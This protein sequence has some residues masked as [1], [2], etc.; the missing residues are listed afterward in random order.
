[1][2]KTYLS[3]FT[4]V[5]P[6]I[7]KFFQTI[8][9]VASEAPSSSPSVSVFSHFCG[10]AEKDELCRSQTAAVPVS[11]G[12]APRGPGDRRH[13]PRL[14]L[15]AADGQQQQQGPQTP[16]CFP[17]ILPEEQLRPQ[18]AAPPRGQSAG[19]RRQRDHLPQPGHAST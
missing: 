4:I 18:E 19:R 13:S 16:G 9:D 15:S 17:R 11:E 10:S 7:G 14:R 6:N 8:S 5:T 1:M 2:R 12:P 3:P